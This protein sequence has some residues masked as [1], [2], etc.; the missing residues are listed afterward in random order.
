MKKLIF[1]ALVVLVAA[2]LFQNYTDFK[3]MDLAKTYWKQIDWAD[4]WL[5][6]KKSLP[7]LKPS[8]SIVPPADKQLNIFIR[9]YGFIPTQN[10]IA[11]GSRVTWYNEDTEKHTIT[12]ENW[13]SGEL[14][15]SK[16]YSRVFEVPG[17]YPYHC[18][19][20]PSMKGELI[21]E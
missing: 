3:A 14:A 11:K 7:D 4:V 21:V 6:L 10:G 1:F 16:T 12:G 8:Q 13:G 9:E 17:Q 19:S 20:H 5:K 15:P 18:S 2:W